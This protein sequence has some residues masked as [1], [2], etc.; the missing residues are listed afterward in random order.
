MP[1]ASRVLAFRVPPQRYTLAGVF[2]VAVHGMLAAVALVLARDS[3]WL[4]PLRGPL[5]GRQP[6]PLPY[7]LLL[8]QPPAAVAARLDVAA[9]PISAPDPAPRQTGRPQSPVPVP[10]QPELSVTAA[11][12]T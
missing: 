8:P 12:L 11:V 3:L 9:T 6:H 7:V 1:D 2:S 4:E 10:A 5:E